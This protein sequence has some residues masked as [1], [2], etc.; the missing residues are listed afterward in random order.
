MNLLTS[1]QNFAPTLSTQNSGPILKNSFDKITIVLYCWLIH[2]KPAEGNSWLFKQVITCK[3]P[4]HR[5]TGG[6]GREMLS[7]KNWSTCAKDNERLLMGCPPASWPLI[8]F[9]VSIKSMN[10]TQKKIHQLVG[11]RIQRQQQEI[12]VDRFFFHFRKCAY[13]PPETM[14]VACEFIGKFENC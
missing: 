5:P 2:W 14:S 11:A 13:K 7:T 12:L 6:L 1:L 9:I 10:K 3:T 4:Q 8:R